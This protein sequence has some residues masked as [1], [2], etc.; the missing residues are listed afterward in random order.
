MGNWGEITLL[1]SCKPI[2]NWFSGAHLVSNPKK[3]WVSQSSL[4]SI[5]LVRLECT[6]EYTWDAPLTNLYFPRLHPGGAT[7]PPNFN[8]NTKNDAIFEARNNIFQ[9]ITLRCPFNFWTLHFYFV[10]TQNRDFTSMKLNKCLIVE[11]V[12]DVNFIPEFQP[13]VD[14]LEF[15]TK[16]AGDRNCPLL[17]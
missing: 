2:Y 4:V 11:K 16:G 12:E 1:V 8:I 14:L 6:P 9:G 3:C 13:D 15:E 5:L 10:A 17:Y 7:T